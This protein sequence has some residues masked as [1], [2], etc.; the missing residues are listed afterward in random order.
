MIGLIIALEFSKKPRNN[1]LPL[2]KQM[3][4]TQPTCGH[5]YGYDHHSYN[6][7]TGGP[8]IWGTRI[9]KI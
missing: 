3:N 8:H 1:L 2:Q 9:L 7:R 5:E 6:N 4:P